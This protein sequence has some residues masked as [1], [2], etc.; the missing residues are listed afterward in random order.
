MDGHVLREALKIGKFRLIDEDAVLKEK[1]DKR[2]RIKWLNK[3]TNG[4]HWNFDPQK[5]TWTRVHC[6]QRLS[7][8]DPTEAPGGPSIL[9]L[10][11]VRDTVVYY[12]SGKTD[13]IRDFWNESDVSNRALHDVWHGETIFYLK[14]H[15]PK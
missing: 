13:V 3:A 11:T 9:D 14:G 1:A 4:D 10:D 15:S 6:Q 5:K 2:Q 8:F 7:L 12:N